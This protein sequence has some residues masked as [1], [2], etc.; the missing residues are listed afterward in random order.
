MASSRNRV[1]GS[2]LI[3]TIHHH[4]VRVHLNA[5]F[6]LFLDSRFGRHICNHVVKASFTLPP[7]GLLRNHSCTDPSRAIAKGPSFVSSIL[8]LSE[9]VSKQIVKTH[10]QQQFFEETESHVVM[11]RITATA[12]AAIHTDEACLTYT[13][14]N[15]AGL[16]LRNEMR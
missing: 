12:K 9:K 3:L 7:G 16:D 11:C 6:Y 14:E 2:P 13:L 1:R 15:F 10:T 5:V 4:V 8:L